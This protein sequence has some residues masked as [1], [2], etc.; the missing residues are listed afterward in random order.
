MTNSEL[1]ELVNEVDQINTDLYNQCKFLDK[2]G[3][4]QID[5]WIWME[6]SYGVGH[7]VVV[8]FLGE[9]LYNSE[10]EEREFDEDKNDYEPIGPYLRTKANK[11]ITKLQKVKL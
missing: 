6:I 11:L 1:I 7:Q 8:E 2:R 10:N 5:P 4:E 9:C 3:K